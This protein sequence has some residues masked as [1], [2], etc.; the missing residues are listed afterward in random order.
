VVLSILEAV[1]SSEMP[2]TVYWL[3]SVI[4]QETAAKSL[5]LFLVITDYKKKMLYQWNSSHHAVTY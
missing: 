4:V 5:L 1:C 3:H 2:G